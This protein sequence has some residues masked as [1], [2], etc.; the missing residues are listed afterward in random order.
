VIALDLATLGDDPLRFD[1]WTELV[2]LEY[3]HLFGTA[4]DAKQA[5]LQRRA[6]VLATLLAGCRGLD[7]LPGFGD[8]FA[9]NLARF[10]ARVAATAAR[11]PPALRSPAS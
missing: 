1:A 10:E 11:P 3:R 6:K 2:W 9:A 8:R 7:V 4:P 5:F